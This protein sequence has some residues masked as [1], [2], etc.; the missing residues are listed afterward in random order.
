M[1][2]LAPSEIYTRVFCLWKNVALDN[3]WVKGFRPFISFFHSG[4]SVRLGM[5]QTRVFGVGIPNYAYGV[6]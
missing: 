2:D 5:R 1:L 4:V 6:L 3:A